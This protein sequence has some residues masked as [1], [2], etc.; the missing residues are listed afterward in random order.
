[1]DDE[2]NDFTSQ[3]NASDGQEAPKVQA[4][5]QGPPPGMQMPKT[6]PTPQQLQQILARMTPEQRAQLQKVQQAQAEA[7]I[8]KM[9]ERELHLDDLKGK[10]DVKWFGHAGFKVSFLDEEKIHRN[11]YMDIWIDAADCPPEEKKQPPNDADLVLVTHGQADASMHAPTLIQAGKREE[12][13]IVCSSEVGIYYEMFRK[14]P[15]TFF[16]KMQ[17]GGTKDFGFCKITMVRAEHPSTCA[18]PNGAPI[19]GGIGVGYVITI[20]CHDVRIYHAGDTNLFSDMK[21][22]DELYKPDYA[23][24]PIGDVLGMGPRE[25]AYAVKHFLKNVKTVIPMHFGSIPT[26]TG[27]PEEFEKQCKEMGVEGVEIVHPSKFA[28]GAAII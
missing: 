12:R 18:G 25:A 19:A 20:P 9:Q 7:A 15:N 22:I 23:M 2:L 10:V 5:P 11:I 13:K 1:M 8:K 16:A 4:Q 3:L 24:L 14:I 27:T 17:P 26:L 28:G 6:P 21:L